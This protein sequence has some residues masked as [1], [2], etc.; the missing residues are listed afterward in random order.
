MID[1]NHLCRVSLREII[2]SPKISLKVHRH[3]RGA[4]TPI[5]RPCKL[6]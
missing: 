6:P 3:A 2:L 1:K 4:G 5:A